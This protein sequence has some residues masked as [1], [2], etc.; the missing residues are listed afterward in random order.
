MSQ[1][2]EIRAGFF[3]KR[4]MS[5]TLKF[6]HAWHVEVSVHHPTERNVLPCSQ[7]SSMSSDQALPSFGHCISFPPGVESYKCQL[8]EVRI[9]P[10]WKS[11]MLHYYK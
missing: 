1:I 3:T 6:S 10:W 7:A 9:D 5:I 11:R 2:G 8:P 4:V